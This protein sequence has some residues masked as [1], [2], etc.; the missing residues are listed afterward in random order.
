MLATNTIS[1]NGYRFIDKSIMTPAQKTAMHP[2][3]AGSRACIGIHLAWI[4]LRLGAAMFFRHCRGARL[5][6]CM[7]DEMMEFDNQFLI[8]PKGHCCFIIL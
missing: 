1:F 5:A 2:F 3:G 4:E 7:T 8:A 6:P